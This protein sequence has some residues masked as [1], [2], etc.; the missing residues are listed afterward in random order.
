MVGTFGNARVSIEDET[1][2]SAKTNVP[3]YRKLSVRIGGKTVTDLPEMITVETV[4]AK[5]E[6]YGETLYVVF[7]DENENLKVFPAAY[8]KKDKKCR[9]ETDETGN[10]V[11]VQLDEVPLSESELIKACR[12]SDEVRILIMIMRL[13]AFWGR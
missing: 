12:A 8:D 7:V 1:Y 9:F 11:F 13:Q 4:L 10:F 3:A 2:P 5:D 6:T